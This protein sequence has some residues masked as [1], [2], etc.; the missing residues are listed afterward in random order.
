MWNNVLTHIVK[1]LTSFDVKWNS[2][3]HICEANISQRRYFTWRSHISLAKG[4]FRW[5]KHLPKQVLFS[6]LPLCWTWTQLYF[7]PTALVHEFCKQNSTLSLLSVG[8]IVAHLKFNKRSQ[9]KKPRFAQLLI[10]K[11]GSFIRLG[12]VLLLRSGIRLAPSGICSAS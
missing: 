1:Y 4:E 9:T 2:P 10:R 3:L 6:G 11:L 7:E 12:R 8:Q 5:K